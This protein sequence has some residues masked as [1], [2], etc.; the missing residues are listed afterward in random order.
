MEIEES[1]IAGLVGLLDDMI[2]QGKQIK[3]GMNE[4]PEP[5][6]AGNGPE[7][8]LSGNSDADT[9]EETQFVGYGKNKPKNHSNS[10]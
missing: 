10:V 8:R 4:S 6:V 1:Q 9:D 2:K 7:V 3:L 5:E